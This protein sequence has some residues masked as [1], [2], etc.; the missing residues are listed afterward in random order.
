MSSNKKIFRERL[1]ELRGRRGWSQDHLSARTGLTQ[2]YISQLETGER[3]PPL[4][5]VGVL[6]RAFGL[7]VS[8]FMEET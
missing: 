6:A 4:A 1:R 2:P 8:E 3:D 7:T 5:T